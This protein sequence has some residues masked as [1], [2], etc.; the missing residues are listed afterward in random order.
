[1]SGVLVFTEVKDGRLK[2]PSR[3][4]LSIGVREIGRASATK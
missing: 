2:K 3:E 4:A 1:M